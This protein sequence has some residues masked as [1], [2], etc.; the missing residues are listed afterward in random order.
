LVYISAGQQWAVVNVTNNFFITQNGGQAVQAD[1]GVTTTV[2]TNATNLKINNATAAAYGFASANG[3]QPTSLSPTRG[4]G[5]SMASFC[6]GLGIAWSD[7]LGVSFILDSG[8]YQYPGGGGP[9]SGLNISGG[10]A[11]NITSGGNLNITH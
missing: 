8:A 5:T 4:A 1:A 10:G 2:N 11:I 7:L 6:A 9:V 3:W